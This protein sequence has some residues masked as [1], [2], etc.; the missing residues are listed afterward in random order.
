VSDND[1]PY[2]VVSTDSHAGLSLRSQLR[3][4][5]PADLI[6]DF[7]AFVASVDADRDATA[8]VEAEHSPYSPSYRRSLD[9]M[10][11]CPGAQDAA[12]R[13]HDMDAQ[14]IA[15]EVMFAGSGNGEKMPFVGGGLNAGPKG[16][17]HELIASGCEIWNRGL[18]EFCSAAPD[19][20]LGVMQIAIWDI[21]GAVREI[22][23]ARSEGLHV[24]NLPAP[25]SDYPTYMSPEYEPLWAVCE[26]L[27]VTLTTHS[28]GGDRPLGHEAVHGYALIAMETHWLSRRTVWQLIFGG[29]FDRHPGLRLVLAEQRA[30]WVTETVRDLDS[31]AAPDLEY[32]MRGSGAP[33]GYVFD[34]RA[35]LN[36]M[37]SEYWDANCFVGGSFLAPFEAARY[38]DPG[39]QNVLWGS[40][41]PHTEG[42]WPVTWYTL[43]N[44]FAG[45][46]EPVVRRTLGELATGVYHQDPARMREIADRIGPR[47]S[48]IDSPLRPDEAVPENH[49]WAFREYGSYR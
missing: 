20:M 46:P 48:E 3:Q 19:R 11:D 35:P 45:I 22:R 30:N 47:P 37:P 34:E 18:A 39:M 5:C 14:G 24:L 33:A 2:V 38:A 23:R 4:F 6:D 10:R 15:A 21:D 12:I 17:P 7:D 29:V 31:V 40:D 36:K 42:T 1:R 28:G 25:R 43:R 8:A 27:G 44:T 49:S 41:Y 9:R 13:L 26:D 32:R 16:V